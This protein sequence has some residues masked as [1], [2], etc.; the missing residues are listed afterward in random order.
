MPAA[1]RSAGTQTKAAQRLPGGCPTSPPPPPPGWLS[2][3]W[4]RGSRGSWRAAGGRQREPGR[5]PTGPTPSPP[6]RPLRLAPGRAARGGVEPLSC[7]PRARQPMGG[8]GER[9][10]HAGPACP[11]ARAVNHPP[12]ARPAPVQRGPARRRERGLSAARARRP[13]LR[14][15][16]AAA[17][18]L[19]CPRVRVRGSRR[20]SGTAPLRPQP[21][22][23]RRQ[24]QARAARP[25][26]DARGAGSAPGALPRWGERG[27]AGVAAA[28]RLYLSRRRGGWHWGTPCCKIRAINTAPG[29]GV[30]P[31]A[32]GNS[33][34]LRWVP[35][36]RHGG[37]GP[38]EL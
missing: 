18:L 26:R 34:E 19:L 9:G 30:R 4:P 6:G 36:P 33:F 2:A 25:P 35:S 15:G 28:R 17:L 27:G 12:V 13:S 24:R 1:L 7:S 23:F 5:A 37:R 22:S 8:P 11:A 14:A 3:G 38:L 16:P 10:Q 32:A 31:R 20:R 21:R 29:M